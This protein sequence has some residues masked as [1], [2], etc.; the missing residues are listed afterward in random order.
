MKNIKFS[1]KF[2]DLFFVITAIRVIILALF[3]DSPMLMLSGILVTTN[4]W[5]LFP[6]SMVCS[7]LALMFLVYLVKILLDGTIIKYEFSEDEE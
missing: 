4:L 1:V 2:R 6:L 5:I 7:I 3:L